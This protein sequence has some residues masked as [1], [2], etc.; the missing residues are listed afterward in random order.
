MIAET[1]SRQQA[2]KFYDRIG[3]RYDWFEMYEGKAKACGLKSLRLEPGLRV[4]NV[5][6][7]TGK[8]QQHIEKEIQ[9]DGIAFGLDISPIM[10]R[11]TQERIK[12]PVLRADT[13]QI[14]MQA[15]SMERVYAAYVLDM[16]PLKDIP[17]ILGEFK[18]ILKPGGRITIITL[19]EGIDRSSNMIVSVWKT[20]YKVSPIVCGGCRPLQMEDALGQA[21][22]TNITR[23]VIAQLAIPSE[24]T[25]GQKK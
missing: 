25:S 3:H 2:Q 16:I 4:L 22:F 10:L 11:L 19:T 7:G 15:E 18:R 21:G 9:P 14:P 5:G 13:R 24:I 20:P 23:Q 1:L 17:G 6:V 8:E 12:S